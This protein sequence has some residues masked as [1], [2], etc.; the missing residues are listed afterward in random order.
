MKKLL[1]FFLVFPLSILGCDYKFQLT[2]L[3]NFKFEYFKNTEAEDLAFAVRNHDTTK[4]VSLLKANPK[5]IDFQEPKKKN[6]ILILTV[7]YNLK[8]E[9]EVLL[10]HGANPNLLNDFNNS[11]MFYGFSA[12][13]APDNC[14]LSIPKLLLKYGGNVNHK[15]LQSCQTLI[16]SSI[17]GKIEPYNCFSR[18]KLLLDSGADINLWVK[19]QTHC[20]VNEALLFDKYDVAETLLIQYKAQIPKYGIKVLQ[21]DGF[22]FIPFREYILTLIKKA[23]DDIQKKSLENIL[24]YIDESK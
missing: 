10:K 22:K 5:I 3:P 4:M 14:D 9:C 17:S 24:N 15:N 7:V 18:T 21:D 11:A 19:D 12:V 1:F 6:S 20:P 8:D 16:M 2:E 23:D 13:F